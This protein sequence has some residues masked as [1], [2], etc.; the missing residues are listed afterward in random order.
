[1]KK[2][3]LI[4]IFKRL[5]K[6]S[7][8]SARDVKR[9]I[10]A[11]AQDRLQKKIHQSELRHS[12]Q[13]R[14]CIE[15][16]LPLGHIWQGLPVRDRAIGLF[17]KLGVGNTE[18]HNGVLIYLQLAERKIEIV[19]DYG[20]N[21]HVSEDAWTQTMARMRGAF[22]ANRFED[23]LSLAIEEVSDLLVIHFPNNA[24]HPNELPDAPV[25]L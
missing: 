8:Y 3:T 15:A 7:G 4:Q 11:S 13:I 19:A 17:K 9:A 25:I 18:H 2:L 16:A 22:Q 5:I 1:M 6:H 21:L 20:L 23:G 24:V 12:G 10:P 14:L